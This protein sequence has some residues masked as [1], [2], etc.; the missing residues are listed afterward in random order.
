MVER[1]LREEEVKGSS[2]V[3][4]KRQMEDHGKKSRRQNRCKDGGGGGV[5]RVGMR[6]RRQEG[7]KE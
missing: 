3:G 7:E 5:G 4:E 1:Y 2:A 6:G